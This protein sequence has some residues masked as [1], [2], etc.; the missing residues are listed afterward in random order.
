M[1]GSGRVG[2]WEVAGSRREQVGQG[3]ILGRFSEVAIFRSGT[4]EGTHPAMGNQVRSKKS[5]GKVTNEPKSRHLAPPLRVEREASSKLGQ[6]ACARRIAPNGPQAVCAPSFGSRSRALHR[7]T[8]V[9]SPARL[10]HSKDG[11][12]S[13]T[14][15]T[16][17]CAGVTHAHDQQ[18][19][20]GWSDRLRDCRIGK[21]SAPDAHL[22]KA[23]GR[24]RARGR[25][26][27]F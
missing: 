6:R 26:Q 18:R 20:L 1:R 19:S 17:V 5:V 22:D 9:E 16:D 4:F 15:S 21:S 14:V 7:A 11:G 27:I 25:S 3:S 10:T 2:R 13:Y 24:R 12:M 23:R 8:P